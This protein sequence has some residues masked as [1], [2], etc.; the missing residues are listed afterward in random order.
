MV[1]SSV[2]SPLDGLLDL[3]CR[4]GVD[5]RPTLLRVLTDLYVQKP[6]HTAEEETHYVELALGLIEAVDQSTHAAVAAKLFAYRAAPAALKQRL[7]DCRPQPGAPAAQGVVANPTRPKPDAAPG[8]D[9]V[10]LFFAASSRERCLILSNLD[11]AREPIPHV[12][13]ATSEV[14]RSL[15]AAALQRR[16]T[17]FIRLLERAL[18]ISRAFAERIARD[19]LGEPIVVAAK[20][21]GVPAAVIQ[22]ILLVLNPVIGQSIERVLSLSQLFDDMAPATAERM[23]AIWRQAG[24]ARGPIYEP[25]HWDDER[26][27]A[28]AAA[29]PARHRAPRSDDPIPAW[30]EDR[31]R[32]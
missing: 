2:H 16:T 30:S 11:P 25:M 28:R 22:R 9:L 24:G 5:I 4:D 18:G 29:T 7:A 14:I 19:E 31:G 1:K 17:E 8:H 23:V 20:A 27:G 13:P 15:E 3:A 12:T 26:R 32:A 10:E 6:V 21:L